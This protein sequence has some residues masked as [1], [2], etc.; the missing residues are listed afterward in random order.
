MID[1]IRASAVPSNLMQS[2]A[3]GALSV[4]PQEIIEIL[5]F[6]THNKVFAEKARMTLAGWD[7]T[8]SR[9]A[10]A[11]SHTPKEVLDYLIAPENLRPVLVP[12]LLENPSVSEEA[13]APLAASG[14]REIV[15]AML[16]SA[17]VS[18]SETILT[19][20]NSNPNLNQ[21]Q[22]TAVEQKLSLLVAETT[23]ASE[24]SAEA[25]QA[26]AA[27]TAENLSANCAGAAAIPEA[28]AEA[29]SDEAIAAFL[30]EHATEIAAEADKPFQPISESHDELPADSEPAE[31]TATVAAEP[32]GN[33]AAAAAKRAPIK[34]KSFLGAG[35]EKGSALQKIAQLDVKGR[36]QLAMKGDREERSLLIRDGTKVVAV[37]VLESP[38]LTDSEVE[39]FASQKNVLEAVLR[40][41][42][43][44]RK[45]MKQYPVIRNLA[46]NPRA[47]IDVSLGIMKHLLIKDLRNLAGNKEVSDTVRKL[48]LKMFKQ[49]VDVATQRK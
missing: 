8:S 46:F 33:P 36:V 43:M 32:S 1:L 21:L 5:V 19:A 41:I 11:D 30:A 26:G 34:K 6:L 44:K 24:P 16:K 15:E 45:F 2:A 31:A 48:A 13:L 10:A 47:P 27:A 14:S 39:K 9:A 12:A 4:P 37:A 7:E 49:K 25:S 35:H 3:R 17:R 28:G 23:K 20:V 40:A 18:R 42:S 22:I 29:L 38:K